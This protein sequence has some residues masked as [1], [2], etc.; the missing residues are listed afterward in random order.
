MVHPSLAPCLSGLKLNGIS[1]AKVGLVFGLESSRPLD[2]RIPSFDKL[3]RRYNPRAVVASHLFK[4]PILE[5]DDQIVIFGVPVFEGGDVQSPIDP[6]QLFEFDGAAGRL[7]KLN[8]AL[9]AASG[10]RYQPRILHVEIE[11]LL[12]I[13]AAD[14][15]NSKHIEGTSWK[16]GFNPGLKTVNFP[17]YPQSLIYCI[18]SG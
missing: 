16:R 8:D 18:P 1:I 9:M 3:L 17:R 11:G 12:A 2:D 14:N 5:G 13:D 10:Y 6:V 4:A 15:G 7:R